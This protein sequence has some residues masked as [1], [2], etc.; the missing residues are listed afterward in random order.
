MTVNKAE[1]APTN[2]LLGPDERL[3][4]G[5]KYRVERKLGSGSH[6]IVEL[7]T[8]PDGRQFV[9]KSLRDDLAGKEREDARWT[10]FR[11]GFVLHSLGQITHYA[12][13]RVVHSE[14]SPPCILFEH[15]TGQSLEKLRQPNQPLGEAELRNIIAAVGSALA[16]MHRLPKE[17][18]RTIARNRHVLPNVMVH[19]DIKPS[20]ILATGNPDR[21]YVLLDYGTALE[22]LIDDESGVA[23]SDLLD[24]EERTGTPQYWDPAFAQGGQISPTADVYS[25]AATLLDLALPNGIP[26]QTQGEI[27][28]LLHGRPLID[29]TTPSPLADL[30]DQTQL[31]P[32]LKD[33]LKHSLSLRPTERPADLRDF[34]HQLP[35]ER[36]DFYTVDAD[37]LVEIDQDF[38]QSFRPEQAADVRA[39]IMH[40]ERGEG[41]GNATHFQ[42]VLK[43]ADSFLT[44]DGWPR[45]PLT[46]RFV[47]TLLCRTTVPM[48]EIAES[49]STTVEFLLDLLIQ[50]LRISGLP[51]YIDGRTLVDVLARHDNPEQLVTAFREDDRVG[52]DP[53]Q[54][55]EFIV[56]LIESL[57]VPLVELSN[58]AR[59]KTIKAAQAKQATSAIP[60]SSVEQQL[61]LLVAICRRDPDLTEV[62]LAAFH[63]RPLARSPSALDWLSTRILEYQKRRQKYS[64]SMTQARTQR[65]VQAAHATLAAWLDPYQ[66]WPTDPPPATEDDLTTEVKDDLHTLV[67]VAAELDHLDGEVMQAWIKTDP[68]QT[69]P[70]MNLAPF[71]SNFSRRLKSLLDNSALGAHPVVA[72]EVLEA[73]ETSD[74][75]RKI[76]N[77]VAPFVTQ[78]LDWWGARINYDRDT[79]QPTVLIND[80]RFFRRFNL[81]DSTRRSLADDLNRPIER[82]AVWL[83]DCGLDEKART[84]RLARNRLFFPLQ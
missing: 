65:Y 62:G 69:S 52:N 61:Q 41:W 55:L 4:G 1:G 70:Q 57:D 2:E 33:L 79:I 16:T 51:R 17:V 22:N 49:D 26:A 27:E 64:T 84:L 80:L 58:Q 66:L 74:R 10:I 59:A 71:D 78:R 34:L 21:P 76:P 20:N 23:R 67:T 46:S 8:A 32:Q 72:M 73:I 6:G 3:V 13:P 81:A 19:L 30:V 28:L 56:A 31:S 40:V 7:V 39:L 11:E 77:L 42:E 15:V 48:I 54:T 47:G 68:T 12:L 29:R 43:R 25:F 60:Q 53:F 44:R 83:E 18:G 37:G 36:N 35:K 38:E 5:V 50:H 14:V 9:L 24:R 63:N 75:L 82:Y 45:S